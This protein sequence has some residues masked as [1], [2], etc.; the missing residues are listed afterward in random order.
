MGIWPLN[1]RKRILHELYVSSG[2]T[3]I[4]AGLIYSCL[5]RDDEKSAISFLLDWGKYHAASDLELTCEICSFV[6]GTHFYVLG[7]KFNSINEARTFAKAKGFTI[8][9]VFEVDGSGRN[10]AS[11]REVMRKRE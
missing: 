3:E 10:A 2:L 8:T 11:L 6:P 4:E 9:R 5:A 1:I 7:E